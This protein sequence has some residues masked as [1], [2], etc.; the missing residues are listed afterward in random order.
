MQKTDPDVIYPYVALDYD[1]DS[2]GEWE[3]DDGGD[4]LALDSDGEEDSIQGEDDGGCPLMRSKMMSKMV[5]YE[6][7]LS[8]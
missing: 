6:E 7:V 3:E 5:L 2:E 8:R 1:Y 4:D